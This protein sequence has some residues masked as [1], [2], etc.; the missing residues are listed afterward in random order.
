MIAQSSPITIIKEIHH[1]LFDL[2]L[3]SDGVVVRV[4]HGDAWYTMVEAR[5]FVDAMH[6]ITG[7]VPHPLLVITGKRSSID[8]EARSYL[9]SGEALKDIKA[10]AAVIHS[11]TQSI[12][13]NL[14]IIVD[15]PSKPVKFFNNREAAEDWL[16]KQVV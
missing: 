15:K 14:F 8:K 5:D 3:R 9:A 16:R 2:Y 10:M 11:V 6:K 1:R 4:S 13:A 12:I 7:G